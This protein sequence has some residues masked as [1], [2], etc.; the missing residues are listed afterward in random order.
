MSEEQRGFALMDQESRR[1][2]ARKGGR[3][4]HQRGT[5]H[6]WT[7]DEAREAGR[8]GGAVLLRSG[9]KSAPS[10]VG[11]LAAVLDHIVTELDHLSH[12]RSATTL[13]AIRSIRQSIEKATDAVDRIEK[14]TT[15]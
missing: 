14:R 5:A 15:A 10:R 7:A 11:D 8:K 1:E 12:S 6:E 4:A 3:T 13:R 2:V 9:D